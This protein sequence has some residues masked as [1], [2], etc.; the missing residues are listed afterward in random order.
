MSSKWCKEDVC[1]GLAA[2]LSWVVHMKSIYLVM[3]CSS[4]SH[5]L[6][7][8]GLSSLK[9]SLVQRNIKIGF[10]HPVTIQHIRSIAQDDITHQR[11]SGFYQR[12]PF[13]NPD[14]NPTPQLIPQWDQLS[15]AVCIRVTT[16][17]GDSW[18]C[19]RFYH[20]LLK[21]LLTV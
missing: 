2:D 6:E 16:T 19:V 5:G 20:V 10:L 1:A 12:L 4:M 21:S 9:A 13:C 8:Q 11:Q 15:C 7:E 3:V 14:L 18:A 17:L